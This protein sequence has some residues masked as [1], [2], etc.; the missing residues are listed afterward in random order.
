VLNLLE[1]FA[2]PYRGLTFK[3]DQS[4]DWYVAAESC[5]ANPLCTHE[6]NPAGV[7]IRLQISLRELPV[8]PVTAVPQIPHD[9]FAL[10]DF[11]PVA[12]PSLAFEE[13]LAEKIRAASQR[14]KIRDLH[15]LAE[16]ANRRFDRVLVRG[17]AVLKLW[18]QGDTLDYG[19]LVRRIQCGTDYDIP[20]LTMLL[21]KDQRPELDKLIERVVEGYRFLAD[22][23]PLERALI[24]DTSMKARSD[25]ERL[26]SELRSRIA[27]AEGH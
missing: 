23:G 9:Y 17:I 2:T 12:V 18:S 26:S 16:S 11:E 6:G 15:D 22:I 20:D 25:A 3:I 8:L 1:A 19:A 21:R 5:G 7:R 10:L 24:G 27:V 4:N 13:I 14:S